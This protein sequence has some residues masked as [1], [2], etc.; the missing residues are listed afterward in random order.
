MAETDT[1]DVRCN[2]CGTGMTWGMEYQLTDSPDDQD[3]LCP[4]C[5][6]SR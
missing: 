3:A 6:H 4:D 1:A 5:F 2:E